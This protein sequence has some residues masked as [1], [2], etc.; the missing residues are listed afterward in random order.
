MAEKL[1]GLVVDPDEMVEMREGVRLALR[2]LSVDNL[3][4]LRDLP[5]TPLEPDLTILVGQNGGGK[6]SFI[7]ALSMLLDSSPPTDEARSSS[8]RDITVIGEFASTDESECL[9]VRATHSTG[10]VQREVM[11]L[12]HPHF[13][14]PPEDMTIHALRQAFAS[15]GIESP[16]GTTKAPFV[17]AATNWIGQRP[18]AELQEAWVVLPSDLAALLPQLTVFRSQDAADQ[19]TQVGRLIVQESQKLLATEAYTPRLNEIAAEIREDIEPVLAIVKK[20]IGRY[21]PGINDVAITTSFDFSRVSPQVQ[22][23]LTKS[24]GESI[25]LNEA[26]SGLMQRVGLAMYAATLATLQETTADPVGTLLAY[27]EPDTHLDYQAQRE[28]SK[29]IR[30]QGKLP[31]VQV[32]VATHSV[33][34]IDTVTLQSL[35]HFQLEGQRT[36]VDIPSDYGDGDESAFVDDLASGLGMRNSVL[37]SEKCFLVVEGSTEERALLILFKKMTGETLA[38]AGITLVNTD[39]AGSVRRLVEVLI[40]K[41]KR[42]VVVLVDEDAR[43]S[44]G[45]INEEWLSEMQ[46]TEGTNGFFTGTKEF[47]D[48]FP[49][50]V[51]LRVAK[52]R[53]PLSDG[54]EWQLNEFADARAGEHGMGQALEILFSRRLHFRVSKPQIGEAL[55]RTVTNDE[56][57]EIIRQAI[58]AALDIS[59]DRGGNDES[60]DLR[61]D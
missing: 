10:R 41:L 26:G 55:A 37:L 52:E 3:R 40:S 48:T 34:L 61:G 42:S 6:T 47:E 13:G 56:I 38:G 24:S 27:D 17:E 4:S 7:D 53:F 35:R 28:L 25:D 12:V 15:A 31:H 2:S 59:K 8:D 9:S 23:R 20:M 43:H 50:E 44:P 21:C 14:N 58:S 1:Q 51:W 36:R 19:P 45:R 5:P 16:G 33:N 49:D 11:R 39:G 54:T 30:G 46:L 22:M 29:I 60:T 32:V 57:P 18:P